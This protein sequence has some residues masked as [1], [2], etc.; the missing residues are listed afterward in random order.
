[1]GT[2]RILA[3]QHTPEDPPGLVLDMA[4]K[5]HIQIDICTS[6]HEPLPDVLYDYDMLIIFGGQEHVYD[7]NRYPFITKEKELTRKAL[8]RGLPFL[9]ICF[10]G[11]LLAS[12]LGA[13]I[14]RLAAPQ[15]GLLNVHIT[16]A[17]RRDPIYTGMPAHQLAFQWHND[18]FDLPQDGVLLA[19]SQGRE[20]Q[21]FRFGPNA[22]GIQY[23]IEL[24][25][26]MFEEQLSDKTTRRAFQHKP[27]TYQHIKEA[28]RTIYPTYE[29]HSRIFLDNLFRIGQLIPARSPIHDSGRY[30][31]TAQ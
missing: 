13:R 25:P 8:A 26:R 23:H 18:V 30:R 20:H 9:G 22:Y 11:Q 28:W 17:G 29:E 2:K 31:R 19:T 12:A 16:D 3:L 27:E 6:S 14:R 10:G 24:T 1:M 4:R 7:E 5:Q 15:I 21:A